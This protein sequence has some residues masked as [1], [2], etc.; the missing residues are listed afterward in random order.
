MAAFSFVT[1][2]GEL[3][4]NKF[5]LCGKIVLIL[6]LTGL[7]LYLI[8]QD[9]TFFQ[10]Q[11]PQGEMARLEDVRILTQELNSFGGSGFDTQGLK[12][13]WMHFPEGSAEYLDYGTYKELMAC[14]GQEKE[15]FSFERKYREDFT[16]LAKDWYEAYGKLLGKLGLQEEIRRET[17]TLLCGNEG[18]TG[19]KRLKEGAVMDLT[20][21]VYFPISEELKEESFATIEAY[22]HVEQGVEIR[23]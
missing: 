9:E 8:Y 21:Q 16:V 2:K 13:F 18:L 5:R 12:A 17:L 10:L 15:E 7:L 3:M 22:V 19:D 14:L 11:Q 20:G 1:N 6:L 23:I 4:K